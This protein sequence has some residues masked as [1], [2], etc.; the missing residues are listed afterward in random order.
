[1][2]QRACPLDRSAPTLLD[3]AHRPAGSQYVQE[4][5]K[6]PLRTDDYVMGYPYPGQ[7]HLVET[8][9]ISGILA[10]S[11]PSQ[12]NIA[13]LLCPALLGPELP[14]AIASSNQLEDFRA[15]M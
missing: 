14:Y 2:E 6:R 10:R 4:L 13:D 5:H 9:G 1:M 3:P 7:I 12:S 11:L 8:G 15:A